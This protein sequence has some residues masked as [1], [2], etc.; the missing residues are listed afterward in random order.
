MGPVVPALERAAEE[1][2]RPRHVTVI[3]SLSGLLGRTAL[4]GAALVGIGRDDTRAAGTTTAHAT[5]LP[6]RI[7]GVEVTMVARP[8]ATA[9]ASPAATP[10]ARRRPS[11]TTSSRPGWRPAAPVTRP[12][13]CR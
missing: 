10:G 9:P 3:A 12:R 7:P 2:T 8:A 13:R 4:T 11:A 5:E 1:V 6:L